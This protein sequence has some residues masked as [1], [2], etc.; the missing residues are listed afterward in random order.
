VQDPIYLLGT[1]DYRAGR[2]ARFIHWKASAR[3]HRLQEKIFDPSE[4]EKVLLALD[5]QSYGQSEAW[6]ELE[7][8]LEVVA[9][10]AVEFDRRA[11]AFGFACNARMVGGAGPILSVAGHRHQV[12]ALL[13]L[14]ARI[15]PAATLDLKTVLSRGLTLPWG[16]SALVFSHTISAELLAVEYFFTQRRIPVVWVVTQLPAAQ[17]SEPV[18]VNC[19][20]MSID[21]IWA[22]HGS[23]P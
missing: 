16:T 18:K 2:P 22:A 5:V 4:Q 19:K 21:Q 6:P 11:S 1:R 8:A 10:L 20:I 3:H 12:S 13:D 15:Q 9:S 23:S 7:R 14:L 17:P